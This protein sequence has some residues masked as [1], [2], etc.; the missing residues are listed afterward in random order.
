[1]RLLTQAVAAV[2]SCLLVL[3][4]VLVGLV[5]V[6]LVV[7]QVRLVLTEL[8]TEV[9]A[10]AVAVRPLVVQVRMVVTAVLELLYCVILQATQLP[11]EQDL[12]DLLQP[13]VLKR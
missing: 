3:L 6:E 2:E 11:L 9:A 1:V 7:L 8:Q 5:A 4:L 10:V 12:R 13:L